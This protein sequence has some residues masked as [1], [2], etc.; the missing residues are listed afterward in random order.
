[1][2]RVSL[3]YTTRTS[4]VDVFDTDNI[5]RQR[6]I[7]ARIDMLNKDDG[8]FLKAL[9]L[10]STKEA[11]SQPVYYWVEDEILPID[12]Q[13]N[14]AAGY[15]ASDTSI[16]VD[17]ARLFIVN[18]EIHVTRTL[19][20]MRVTAVNYTTNTLTVVR[21]W[22]GSPASA[23]LDNEKLIAGIAHLPELGDA[24][25]GTGRVPDT[26]KY[27]FISMFSESFKI[28]N[29][30]EVCQMIETGVGKVA[31]VEWE[32]VN[33]MFEIKRKVNK[34]LMFQ[35]RGTTTTADGT[36]Y[37]SQGFLHYINDNVLNVGENNEQLTWPILSAFLDQCF[38]ATASSSEKMCNS[39]PYLFGAVQRMSRDMSIPPKRYFHPDL[40]TD[41][42]EV[43]TESGN[44]V[45]FA[46]DR[47][48]FPVDEGLA[49]WG[50][51][52]DMGHAFKREMTG[53]PMTWKQN[54]QEGRNHYR[55]DEYWGSFSLELRHPE[56]HGFIRGASKSIIDHP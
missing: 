15:T 50:I 39:G 8:T 18:S 20:N 56:V 7:D 35:H 14:L 40:Q 31:S 29:L 17:D 55:Q 13:V 10:W 5:F 45:M 22:N 6:D 16:V 48:G 2:Y 42:I 12:T 53:M 4:G 32:V 44:F 54:I 27:N 1:M 26:E 25:S 46:K 28:S 52:V 47:H 51:V 34:A 38:D 30:Q 9:D 49:G 24:N 36:I 41:V 21:G 43:M 23:L 3:P 37:C 19:E 11:L 33:K